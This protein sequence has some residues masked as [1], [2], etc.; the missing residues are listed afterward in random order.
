M[1]PDIFNVQVQWT[2]TQFEATIP[3]IDATVVGATREEVLEQ[4]GRAIVA[5]QIKAAEERKKKGRRGST[6]A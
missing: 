1:V 6:V 2:G 3:E 5:A 4:A